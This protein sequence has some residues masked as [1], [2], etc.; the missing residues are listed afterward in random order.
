MNWYEIVLGV[1]LIAVSVLIVV[2]TLA[3][4]QKGQG[5]S[6]AIMGESSATVAAG[7]VRGVDAKLA[8][9]GLAA[10]FHIGVAG[11][12]QPHLAHG[13]SLEAG[14]QPVGG[15]AVCIGHAFT[16]GRTHE[17]VFHPHPVYDQGSGGL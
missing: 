9:P 13:Q 5:L 1:V 12:D 4:E 16:R 11:D 6:G 2:F 3:Q 15:R 10:L 8:G 17:A 14:L 7:R